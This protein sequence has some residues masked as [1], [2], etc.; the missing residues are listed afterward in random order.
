[1]KCLTI[2]PGARGGIAL[3]SDDII[4]AYPCPKSYSGMANL[5]R[6]IIRLNYLAKVPLYQ[7]IECVLENVHA[8]PTDA[9]SSA[10]KFGRNFGIWIGILES[11][12]IKYKLVTP[13]TWQKEFH[14]LPKNK[15]ERKKELRSIAKGFH[16]KATY[17]TAD[18][19]CMAIWM[20]NQDVYR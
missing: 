11:F 10:F 15:Q 20:R 17:Y 1:M 8:F 19:I 4:E 9:R 5:I 3:L 18:A 16:A 6:E 13:Q 12:E 7:K 2:D 14:P